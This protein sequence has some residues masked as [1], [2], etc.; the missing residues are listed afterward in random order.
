MQNATREIDTVLDT[1]IEH[2]NRHDMPS[3]ASLWVEDADFVNVL[4]RR[5]HG[6]AEILAELQFLHQGPFRSTQVAILERSVRFLSPEVAVVHAIWEMKGVGPMPWAAA[7]NNGERRGVFTHVIEQRPEGWRFIAS[8][9][10]E[11]VALPG[12]SPV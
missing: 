7:H 3:Y 2:W 10:T 12:P 1:L 8:Q 5:L 4:G 9:N 11:T 6:R